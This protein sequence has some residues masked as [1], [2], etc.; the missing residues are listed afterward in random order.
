MSWLKKILQ[1]KNQRKLH[2]NDIDLSIENLL[3]FLIGEIN[4]Y[5]KAKGLIK[6]AKQFQ[7]GNTEQKIT[8]LPSLYLSFEHFLKEID[9]KSL[10]SVTTLRSN[11]GQDFPELLKLESFNI[12]FKDAN[13]QS[14]ILCK[15]FLFEL[16]ENCSNI[17]GKIQGGWFIDIKTWLDTIPVNIDNDSM[18]SEDKLTITNFED[19]RLIFKSISGSINKNFEDKFGEELTQSIVEKTYNKLANTYRYLKGFPA[20]VTIIPDRFLNSEKLSILNKHQIGKVLIEKTNNLERL[21]K[22][23]AGQNRKLQ[24]TQ[25][26][27][28]NSNK[29]L[30]ATLLQFSTVLNTVN[31]GIITADDRGTILMV[32]NFILKLFGYTESELVGKSL[33]IL[34][35]S[36]YHEKHE[37]G[38]QRHLETNVSN[39]LNRSVKVNG[40][41]KSGNLFPIEMNISKGRINEQTIFTAAIKD[42]SKEMELENALL[43]SNEQLELKVKLRT[44]ELTSTQLELKELITELERSNKELEEFGYM[45]SHDLQEPLRTISSYLRLLEKRY[46]KD[47]DKTGLEFLNFAVS[48]AGRMKMLISDLLEYSRAGRGGAKVKNLDINKIELVLN[49]MFKARLNEAGGKL[50]FQGEKHIIADETQ[51]IQLFQNLIGNAI[52]FQKEDR[53]PIVTINI[54]E[55]E[56]NWLISVKDNG[57]GIKEEFQSQIFTIFQ[58]LHT[59]EQYE[60]SGIGLAICKKIVELHK[61][62]IWIESK[63][64]IGTTFLFTISKK[65]S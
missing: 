61:G 13:I 49:N 20:L 52:K 46:H 25:E 62:R 19:W 2:D 26:A 53:N 40:I 55:N 41:T 10:K 23:L 15:F 17:F 48:G 4:N 38:M 39:V 59:R 35:P 32:N 56:K 3:K 60:G 27:L 63:V 54:T 45:V 57:I 50:I 47:L 21:N 22:Q 9:D 42:I 31:Q 14:F 16:L 43:K 12:I 33:K 5:E 6:E 28:Q 1:T 8:E 65:L 24:L 18:F 7:K 64:D 44:E 34:M 51:I 11:V 37:T 58:R 30:E 29:K 36:S